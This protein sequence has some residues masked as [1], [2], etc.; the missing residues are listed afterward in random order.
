MLSASAIDAMLKEKGYKSGTLYKRIED[1]RDNGLLTAEMSD[2]AH[3]IR[4]SANEPRHAD[5]EYGGASDADVDQ[6]LQ[7]ARALG[8][9][10]FVLPVK[11]QKWKAAASSD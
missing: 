11:V 1:A 5:D 2:W 7:F 8:E 9:Y 6:T 4:L 3:E 10:L